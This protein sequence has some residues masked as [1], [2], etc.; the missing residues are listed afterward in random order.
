MLGQKLIINITVASAIQMY[1][2]LLQLTAHCCIWYTNVSAAAATYCT[3]L[4]LI[5]KCISSCCNLLNTVLSDIQMYQQ[6]LQLTVHCCIWYTNVSAAAAT[7][8]TLL[9]LIYKCISSCCNLL[10]TV[11]SDIQMYQQLLQLTVHCCIW[12]TNVSAAAAT[13]CTLLYL[14]YKFY[15]KFWTVLLHAIDQLV[16]QLL[17]LVSFSIFIRDMSV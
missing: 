1:Q 17:H 16:K 10:N 8:C 4:Y 12:Y 15:T 6:L 3:L 11:L 2:Q 7:Y 13:Y 5:Y 9:Y 14:I